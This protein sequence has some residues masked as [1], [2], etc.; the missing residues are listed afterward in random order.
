M[1]KDLST[2][3]FDY[4]L[5]DSDTKG[6]LMW[7]ATEIRKHIGSHVEF[8][9]AAGKMLT[10]AR[11]LCTERHFTMWA[12]S[13]C[14]SSLRSVYN[15]MDAWQGFGKLATVANLELSAMYTLANNEPAKKEALKRASKGELITQK[16]A[17]EITAKHKEDPPQIVQTSQTSEGVVVEP[18]QQ[19][20][21][22]TPAVPQPETTT[23]EQ[24]PNCGGA[25]WTADDA[26]AG[27]K[28]I[29][30]ESLGDPDEGEEGWKIQQKKT[31][32]T[33]EALMR[34]F[35][36]LHEMKRNLPQWSIVVNDGDSILKKLLETA[37]GW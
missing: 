9:L 25:E 20:P 18:P 32:K 4:S 22:S 28:H 30:G 1:A 2:A 3:V 37:K 17:K 29:K 34:A 14:N 7:Y 24:C 6:K 27:C 10:E 16:V 13:E 35:D 11:D 36:D 8:G 23:G 5:V 12:P 33:I 19:N 21:S 15:Y 26:C 31:I